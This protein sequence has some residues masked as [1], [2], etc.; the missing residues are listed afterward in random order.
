VRGIYGEHEMYPIKRLQ[1]IEGSSIRRKSICGAALV[2][3]INWMVLS[4]ER[5]E[6]GY[7]T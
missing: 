2:R 6:R 7:P 4:R 3:G 5:K 1:V